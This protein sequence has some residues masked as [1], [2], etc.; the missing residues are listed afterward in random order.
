MKRS[1]ILDAAKACVCGDRERDYGTPAEN[2]GRIAKLWSAYMDT[3]FT[4]QD[5]AVL[6]ALMKV[7]RI[8]GGDKDDNYIDLAGYAAIAGELG[9][10]GTPEDIAAITS[11]DKS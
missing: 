7:A 2:F 9:E 11:E 3:P 8:R 5:V 6:L 4:S 10:S 1:D